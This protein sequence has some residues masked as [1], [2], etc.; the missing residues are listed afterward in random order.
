MEQ[1]QITNRCSHLAMN[2]SGSFPETMVSLSLSL[3]LSLFAL[4]MGVQIV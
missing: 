4:E 3:S 2:T 1:T